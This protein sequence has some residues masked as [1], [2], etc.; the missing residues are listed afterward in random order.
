MFKR[1]LPL[2]PL[3]IVT[4]HA[5]A[6]DTITVGSL[7]LTKCIDE[8]DGYCGTLTEPFNRYGGTPGSIVIGFEFYPHTDASQPSAGLLLAREMNP[9]TEAD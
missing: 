6:A 4:G 8:Y 2:L 7:T 9:S 1:L 5:R 3:L